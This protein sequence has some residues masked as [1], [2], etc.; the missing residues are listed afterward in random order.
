MKIKPARGRCDMWH[1]VWHDD[2]FFIN[3]TEVQAL[4]FCTI[5]LISGGQWVDRLYCSILCGLC[6]TIGRSLAE[7]GKWS[8]RLEEAFRGPGGVS[9][10]PPQTAVQRLPLH[11]PSSQFTIIQLLGAVIVSVTSLHL[12]DP[13]SAAQASYI[14]TQQRR[15][16][17][18]LVTRVWDKFTSSF[19]IWQP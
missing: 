1:T 11:S 10:A 5:H 6:T 13:Q 17:C 8:Q 18:N 14:I 19:L 7:S 16:F 9:A 4:T 2:F 12:S 3:M 15:W